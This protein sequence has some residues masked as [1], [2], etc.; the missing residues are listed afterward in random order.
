VSSD[1]Q[2]AR[3]RSQAPLPAAAINR[4][5]TAAAL[6]SESLFPVAGNVRAESGGAGVH[7]LNLMPAALTALHVGAAQLGA[8]PLQQ[9]VGRAPDDE[10]AIRRRRQDAQHDGRQV[11][12]EMEEEMEDDAGREDAEDTD[13]ATGARVVGDIVE[14]IVEPA[15]VVQEE[16]LFVDICDVLARDKQSDILRQLQGGRRIAVVFP[17]HEVRDES[18]DKGKKNTKRHAAKNALSTSARVYL[19]WRDTTD[20]GW[21]V[22]L[23]ARLSRAHPPRDDADWMTIRSY[24]DRAANGGW[25]LRVQPTHPGPRIAAI[26]MG[27]VPVLPGAWTQVCLQILNTSR[28]WSA[29]GSQF[30][31][32][33][34]LA[35]EPLQRWD[36]HWWNKQWWDSP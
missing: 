13:S 19:L 18:G 4:V 34:A 6:H 31:L 3:L 12:D 15:M 7:D 30:S 27:A 25:R 5:D 26:Q 28:F 16:G 35:A 1:E 9:S 32:Q 11:E 21:V 10:A 8:T 24:K 14:G 20:E 33:M 29:L 17:L 36:K 2:A 22:D 23:A